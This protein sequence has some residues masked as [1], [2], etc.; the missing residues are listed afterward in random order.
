MVNQKITLILISLFFNNF[1]N[2]IFFYDLIEFFNDNLE[3]KIKFN[4]EYLVKTSYN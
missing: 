4:G 3:R 2:E 1:E